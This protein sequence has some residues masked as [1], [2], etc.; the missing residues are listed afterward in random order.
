MTR[1]VRFT[2]TLAAAAVGS[3]AVAGAA[4][5]SQEKVQLCHG[6]A[7]DTNPYVRIR[8]SESGLAGHFDGTAPGHGKN[9][10]PDFVLPAGASGCAD[11]GGGGEF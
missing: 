9:N 6:T 1:R 2:L 11:D 4:Q 7:S 10:N 5:S 8:V 3:I